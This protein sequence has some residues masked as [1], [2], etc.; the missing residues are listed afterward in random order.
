MNIEYDSTWRSSTFKVK[1]SKVPFSYLSFSYRLRY[2]HF[3]KLAWIPL[4]FSMVSK[5][6]CSI[7]INCQTNWSK[8]VSGVLGYSY[9]ENTSNISNLIGGSPYC[10]SE[11]YQT[12]SSPA[13]AIV[14][15]TLAKLQVF[16]YEP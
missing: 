13:K 12:E 15:S 1:E 10:V 4:Y 11:P 8:D 2:G 7:V 16:R 6:D 3:H 5:S 14:L 9:W